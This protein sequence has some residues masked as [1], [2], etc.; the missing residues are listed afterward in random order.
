MINVSAAW[1]R[2]LNADKRD[3]IERVTITLKDNTVL[4]LTNEN[5][6]QGGFSI[7]DAVSADSDFQVGAAIVN[8]FTLTINNIYEVYSSYVFENALVRVEIGLETDESTE[9]IDKGRYIVNKATYNGS[10]ISLECYDYMVKFD[11]PYNDPVL[12]SALVYPN[13]LQNIVLDACAK[14]GN[15]TLRTTG[16]PHS[17]FVINDRPS[18]ESAT[19]REVIAWCAQIAGCFARMNNVG[20][21]TISWYPQSALEDF[22]SDNL[23]GGVFDSSTPYQSGDSADGGSFN[24]WNTGDVYDAG[25]FASAD[26]VHVISSLYN[27]EFSFDPVII[28]GV[29]ILVKTEIQNEPIKEHSTGTEGYVVEIQN[30]PMVTE[31]NYSSILAWLGTQLIGFRFYRANVSH[32]SD[33]S[34]EAGDV[35]LV[36]DGRGRGYPVVISRTTFSFGSPQTLISSAQNTLRNSVSRFSAETKNYVQMR[37]NID[38]LHSELEDIIAES[39]GLY[40]TV[41]T[42][43]TTGASV[44]YLHNKPNPNQT[45][46]GLSESDIQIR[47]SD[48]GIT[49]TADGGTTWYGLTTTGDMFTNLLSARRILVEDGSGYKLRITSTGAYIIDSSNNVVAEYSTYTRLISEDGLTMLQLKGDGVGVYRKPNDGT[50]SEARAGIYLGTSIGEAVLFTPKFTIS[51]VPY[52]YVLS[53]DYTLSRYASAVVYNAETDDAIS[54]TLYSQSGKTITFTDSSLVGGTY[55]A[56]YSVSDFPGFSFSNGQD[57]VLGS[58]NTFASGNKAKAEGNYSAAFGEGNANGI[59]AMA[60]GSGYSSGDFSFSNGMGAAYGKYSHAEGRSLAF[61]YA[62]HAE[63]ELCQA[64]AKY[65]H[66]EGYYNNVYSIY[67]HGEGAYNECYGYAAHIGGAYCECSGNYSFAHGYGL[68]SGEAVQFVIGKYNKPEVYQWSDPDRTCQY[69]FM[70][71]NGSSDSNRKNALTTDWNGNVQISGTLTQS[72]DKRLKEHISYLSDD[73][74]EFIGSLKPA[75]FKMNDEDHVGFYAQD[76]EES[77]KWGCMIGEMNGYKTLG[78]T[79]IIAPL[80]AY[81]QKLEERIANLEKQIQKEGD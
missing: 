36:F 23:D 33:P 52:S 53:D 6:W 58:V 63:G 70:I 65:C 8:K 18:D 12:G 73:A 80:V 56:K 62:S 81:C 17:N 45:I 26:D 72:S 16:F 77:D 4:H 35:A 48:A 71:G 9:Y 60:V 50:L 7:D 49:V 46:Q 3:F 68:K 40:E 10:L 32:G 27:S 43:S 78:Y 54:G 47:F 41:I 69:P 29:R 1:H 14:C 34:I 66:A 31:D 37:R 61:G 5:I 11:V 28:T 67:C 2:A 79:E 24:P 55:Y 21:L 44:Y 19:Y 42:D 74:V 76:V 20:E 59:C 30:N 25:T 13:T 39:S 15:I 38:D 75:H 22:T 51:S 57:N 64:N